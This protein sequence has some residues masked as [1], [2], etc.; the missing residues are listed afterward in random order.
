MDNQPPDN[1]KKGFKT[2]IR[3]TG[4]SKLRLPIYCPN[5]QCRMITSSPMDDE[6]LRTWGL[7]LHCY[8]TLIENREKPAIDIEYYKKK[9]KEQDY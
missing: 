8:V 9:A 6:S 2:I 1:E 3:K 4:R 7:C 5:P